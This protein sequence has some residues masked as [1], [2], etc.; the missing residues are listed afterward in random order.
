MTDTNFRSYD[1]PTGTVYEIDN[2][3]VPKEEFEARKAA[4]RL[5]LQDFRNAPI[6]GAEDLESFASDARNRLRTK[7]PAR[8]EGGS[9]SLNSCKVST[10]SKNKKSPNW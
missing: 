2:V 7:L 6:E 10:G 1:T 8:K 3:Q 9:I 4:S 5:E